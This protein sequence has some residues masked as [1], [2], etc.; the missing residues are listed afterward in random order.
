MPRAGLR[1]KVRM[2]RLQMGRQINGASVAPRAALAMECQS[3]PVVG[4]SQDVSKL[5][6]A[7]RLRPHIF[8][9]CRFCRAVWVERFAASLVDVASQPFHGL[10]LLVAMTA[11]A[12]SLPAIPSLMPNRAHQLVNVTQVGV[13]GS[14]SLAKVTAQ[15][16]QFRAMGAESV[17]CS[18]NWC[19]MRKA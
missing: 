2:R 15:I 12:L 6:F 18:A 4:I 8:H 10:E 16:S 5:S 1:P 14:F 19:L 9:W 11:N 7:G 13:E 3:Q 17:I